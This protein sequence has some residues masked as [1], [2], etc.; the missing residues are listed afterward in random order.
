MLR[1]WLWGLKL[2]WLPGICHSAFSVLLFPGERLRFSAVGLPFQSS[3]ETWL[4]SHLLFCCGTINY[5]FH[6][7]HVSSMW[8]RQKL[9]HFALFW[10]L[11]MN[12]RSQVSISVDRSPLNFA[13]SIGCLFGSLISQRNRD[14]IFFSFSQLL[15]A[16]FPLVFPKQCSEQ[17][18]IKPN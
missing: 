13:K 2:L 10:G 15:A 9:I 1:V 12:F 14:L 8:S 7:K 3:R 6:Y 18:D 11:Y 5:G 17:L 4:D 16:R